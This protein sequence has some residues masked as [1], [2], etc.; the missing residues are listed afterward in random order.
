MKRTKEY[1][2]ALDYKKAIKIY[3]LFQSKFT[4]RKH[5]VLKYFHLFISLLLNIEI[6]MV[7]IS[8]HIE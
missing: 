3:I 7:Y 2:V 5:Q 8:S 4:I 1:S 6:E